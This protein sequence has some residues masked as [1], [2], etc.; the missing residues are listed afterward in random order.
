M[1]LASDEST[2]VSFQD[3]SF[4]PMFMRP[5]GNTSANP[6][7]EPD[8]INFGESCYILPCYLTVLGSQ[9]VRDIHHLMSCC[10][11]KIPTANEYFA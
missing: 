2:I 7:F 1:Y 9:R 6:L 4:N 8:D 3:P 10:F 11:E 5:K